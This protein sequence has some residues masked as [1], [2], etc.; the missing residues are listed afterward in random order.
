MGVKKNIPQFLQV[1]NLKGES[2]LRRVAKV[3]LKKTIPLAS[4]NATDLGKWNTYSLDLATLIKTEPGAIY[5][6]ILRIKKEYS[7]SIFSTIKYNTIS[8]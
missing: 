1:N 6:V 5:K 3:V 8:H 4:K 2:E 7:T